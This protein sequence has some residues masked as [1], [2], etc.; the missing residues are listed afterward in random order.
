MKLLMTCRSSK[1]CL[2][3]AQSYSSMPTD[4]EKLECCKLD[5]GIMVNDH[6]LLGFDMIMW[7]LDTPVGVIE[8][9]RKDFKFSGEA[10][11]ADV[12]V[13]LSGHGYENEDGSKS[14]LLVVDKDGSADQ[15]MDLG[16]V[17]IQ[18]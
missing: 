12:V 4:V 3:V 16:N 15:T 8:K 11:S 6:R 14:Y 18:T 1:K 10:K 9:A 5:F 13:Y 2:G 17:C 7:C